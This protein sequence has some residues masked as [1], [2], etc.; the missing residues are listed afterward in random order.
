M[1]NLHPLNEIPEAMYRFK[2]IQT[3]P[4]AKQLVDIAR[5]SFLLPK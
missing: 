4:P 3:I 5:C 1:R 2:E